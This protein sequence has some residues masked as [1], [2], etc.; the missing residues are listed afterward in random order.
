MRE[1]V[2][3]D[4]LLFRIRQRGIPYDLPRLI[5]ETA[6]EFYYDSKTK[7]YIAIAQVEY[8]EKIREMIVVFE[9]DDEISL[10]TIHPI[11]REQKERRIK[12]GRWIRVEVEL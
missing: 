6:N 8:R 2:Y 4:H 10:I 9:I 11:K 1:I 3:T 12:S 5:L 7:H